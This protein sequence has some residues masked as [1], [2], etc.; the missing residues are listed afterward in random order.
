MLKYDLERKGL[1][2]IYMYLEAA[3]PEDAKCSH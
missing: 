3:S 1:L 2:G